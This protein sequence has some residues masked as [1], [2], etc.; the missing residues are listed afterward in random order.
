MEGG[1][2]GE[3]RMGTYTCNYNVVD[4]IEDTER[5]H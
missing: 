2:E 3:D 1:R 5:L 4:T